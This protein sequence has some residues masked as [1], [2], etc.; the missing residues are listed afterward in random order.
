V[1]GRGKKEELKLVLYQG[2]R[3]RSKRKKENEINVV[4]NVNK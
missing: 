1:T 4:K 2:C 3:T